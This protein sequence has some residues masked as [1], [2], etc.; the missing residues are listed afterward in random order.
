MNVF[1][2]GDLP[3]YR[4]PITPANPSQDLQEQIIVSIVPQK[5]A[6][7]VTTERQKV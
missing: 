2:H 1:R 5:R 4:E 3:R 6:P 7:S